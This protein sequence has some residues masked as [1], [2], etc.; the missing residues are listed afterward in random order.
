MTSMYNRDITDT[1]FTWETC[2]HTWITTAV[3]GNAPRWARSNYQWYPV[4][5]LSLKMPQKFSDWRFLPLGA[6]AGIYSRRRRKMAESLLVQRMVVENVRAIAWSRLANLLLE[7]RRPSESHNVTEYKS[8]TC[9]SASAW[10]KQWYYIEWK[11]QMRWRSDELPE[12]RFCACY[13]L[14]HGVW[15]PR[16][17][18]PP[19]LVVFSDS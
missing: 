12:V 7:L 17:R 1:N 14:R 6:S 16:S 3:P 13:S 18:S 19:P 9:R 10:Q 15:H 8:R 2:L 4:G 11:M 5:L